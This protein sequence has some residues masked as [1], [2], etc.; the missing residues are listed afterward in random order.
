[1]MIST[2]VGMSSTSQNI[3]IGPGLI[4]I[5]TLCLGSIAIAVILSRAAGGAKYVFKGDLLCHRLQ[6][7]SCIFRW[8]YLSLGSEGLVT[9]WI[10]DQIVLLTRSHT[11]LNRLI[12]TRVVYQLNWVLPIQPNCHYHLAKTPCSFGFSIRQVRSQVNQSEFI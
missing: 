11:L 7:S 1:M 2:V 10:I 4:I 5:S 12:L 9:N 8:W 6:I 3:V